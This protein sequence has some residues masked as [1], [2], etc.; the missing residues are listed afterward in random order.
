MSEPIAA[1]HEAAIAC[2]TRAAQEDR[3]IIAAW[4][5]G[6]RADGSAD[7]FSDIDF[8]VAVADDE[9]A[10]FDGLAFIERCAPVLVHAG[11]PGLKAVVCLL[12]GPVKLDFIIER[13]STA[14]DM[15]RPAARMLVDKAGLTLKTGWEPD[16]RAV[17]AQIDAAVRLTF[18]GASWPVRLL[19]RDQWMTFA[20]SELTLIHNLIVPLMLVQRDRRA[21]ARNAMT[22][23]RLLQQDERKEVAGLARDTAHAVADYS[24]SAAYEAHIRLLNTL[25]RV[26]QAACAAY[27]LDYPAAAEAEARRFFAREWPR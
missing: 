15:Q 18:Q 26:A 10:A 7:D 17:A 8:Y 1:R 22:R 5:Q 24:S 6:S 13:A 2:L 16:E 11:L 12:A 27:S 23:E 9:Y 25:S 4:L 21:F 14:A 19:R 20:C 3:R